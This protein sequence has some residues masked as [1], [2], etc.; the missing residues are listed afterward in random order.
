MV[1]GLAITETEDEGREVQ[2]VAAD[3]NTNVALPWLSPVTTPLLFIL[4]TVDWRLIHVPPEFGENEVVLPTHIG[5]G[6]VSDITGLACTVI[7]LLMVASH[8]VADCTYLKLA[9]PAPSPV[10]NP[11]LEMLATEGV[12]DIQV[13]P[14][15]GLSCVV[16]PIQILDG[17]IRDNEGP[18]FTASTADESDTQPVNEFVNTKRAVPKE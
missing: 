1:V 10:T 15:V 2:P 5:D 18:L 17:P 4:A 3:V 12:S 9:C 6:P 7:T 11:A 14:T 8:P 13:P 16:W